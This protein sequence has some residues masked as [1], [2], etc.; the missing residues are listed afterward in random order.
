V[1]TV[2][3]NRC[4][5]LAQDAVSAPGRNY[6]TLDLGG[7]RYAFYEHLK[8]GSITV[9]RGDRVKSGQVIGLLGN[10]VITECAIC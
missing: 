4:S 1:V 7:S 3:R 2:G 9:R 6:V 10:S 5:A 8:H